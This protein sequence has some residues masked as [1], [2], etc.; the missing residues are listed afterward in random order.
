MNGSNG[1]EGRRG[2]VSALR[3][4]VSRAAAEA[5]AEIA[6]W[7]HLEAKECTLCE[8]LQR[9]AASCERPEAVGKVLREKG[10]RRLPWPGHPRATVC[11]DC[12]IHALEGH[13][14]VWWALCWRG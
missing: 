8:K 1:S 3:G 7:P 13:H 10:S 11:K 4:T 2:M 9:P 12:C 6:P 14:C 5:A